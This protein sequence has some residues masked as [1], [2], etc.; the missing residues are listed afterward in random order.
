MSLVHIVPFDRRG[1]MSYAIRVPY[2]TGFIEA[3]KIMIV[4]LKRSWSVEMRAWLIDI[5]EIEKLHK[6]LNVMFFPEEFCTFCWQQKACVEWHGNI[7]RTEGAVLPWPSEKP[8]LNVEPEV[9]PAPKPRKKAPKAPKPPKEPREPKKPRKPREPKVKPPE[10]VQPV[11]PPP[12][13]SPRPTP[14][15]RAVPPPMPRPIRGVAAA[16][17]VLGLR[18]PYTAAEVKSAFRKK[19]LLAHPDRPGGSTAAFVRINDASELLLKELG[20]EK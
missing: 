18:Y 4:P 20:E 19:A 3:L 16:E 8:K 1:I 9:K 13:P 10:P 7:P 12:N 15:P 5:S 6:I 14:P 17:S 11:K 2:H